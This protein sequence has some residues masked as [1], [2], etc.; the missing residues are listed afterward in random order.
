MNTD[1]PATS[2]VY[3][4]VA[5]RRDDYG[6]SAAVGPSRLP[7]GYGNSSPRTR[8]GAHLTLVAPL[9]ATA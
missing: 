5:L 9:A 2:I 7:A 6:P 1:D 4:H 8:L 3:R